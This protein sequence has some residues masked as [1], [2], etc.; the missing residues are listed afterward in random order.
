VQSYKKNGTLQKNRRKFS[1]AT[2]FFAFFTFNPQSSMF[3]V[4]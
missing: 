4:Q 1:F 3:N 2:A